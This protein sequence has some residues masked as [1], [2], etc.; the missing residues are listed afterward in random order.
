MVAEVLS[1]M[2]HGIIG[3]MITVQTDISEG[4]PMF[5]VI[6]YLS[7]EVKEAK[8]RVRTALKNSGFRLP[9]KR[10]AANLAPADIRKSGTNFDLAIAISLLTA[11]GLIPEER[12][13][14]IFFVGELAL[15]GGLSPVTGVLPLLKTARENGCTACILPVDNVEEASLL[16]GLQIGGFYHLKEVFAF[17][18][19]GELSGG[20][21]TE[22]GGYGLSVQ[23]QKRTVQEGSSGCRGSD[24]AQVRGQ[25]MAKR[26]L[27]IAVSGYHNLF[28]DGP[29]GT[30][31][32]M[33]ASCVPG[34]MPAMEE[35]EIIETTMIYSVRGLLGKAFAPVGR[36]P[37]RCP[38]SAVTMAGM[39][40]GGRNLKPGEVSLAHRGVLFLDEFPEFKKE[41]IEMFRVPL[42][43]Q[44]ITQVRNGRSIVFPADFLFIAA[45]N[46]CPCGY[47]PD[48]KRCHC[49]KGQ[50]MQYQ[51]RISG[52]ILDRLDLFV[53]CD[54]LSYG[55]LTG[56][57]AEESSK[58]VQKRIDTVWK[59]QKERYQNTGVK[60]NGRMG[61]KEI[62]RYCVLERDSQE[63]LQKAFETFSMTGRTYHRILKVSRTIADMEGEENIKRKHV[64]EA[65]L[66]RRTML[67]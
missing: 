24:L 5:T 10:I 11:M 50:V 53:R 25:A 33:L 3:E 34:I 44:Q 17:L 9:P 27:E 14:G 58:E 46:P 32:S 43:E 66:Y 59:I 35:E 16:S 30:G 22:N 23:E 60:F 36:R 26:A 13:K 41:V 56:K 42:E 55:T 28:L 54:P 63:L 15:D 52:P 64:E 49:S 67:G 8:E 47:Y 19:K 20:M 57:K 37:F 31:K 48:R 1:G 45:A 21:L 18:T 40:G 65:L 7:A 4:L 12:V 62:G 6:G 39:F 29:P 51:S 61:Q 2:V 38:S